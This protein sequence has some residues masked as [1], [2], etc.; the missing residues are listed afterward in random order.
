MKRYGIIFPMKGRTT[1]EQKQKDEPPEDG[2]R[3]FPYDLSADI[4]NRWT[5]NMTRTEGCTFWVRMVRKAERT[6]MEY[7]EAQ[8]IMISAF[9]TVKRER[10]VTD[11]TTPL[12]DEF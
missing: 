1:E 6:G 12:L 9:E 5:S 10:E 3:W 2:S 4:T 11:A 8:D 7:S